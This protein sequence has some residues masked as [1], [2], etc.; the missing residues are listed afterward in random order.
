MFKNNYFYRTPLVVASD[1]CCH[2]GNIS[3]PKRFEW[4]K[5]SIYS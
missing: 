1:G 2:I 3:A 5:K 4:F